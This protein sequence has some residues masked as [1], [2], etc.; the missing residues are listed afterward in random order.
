LETEINEILQQFE[1]AHVLQKTNGIGLDTKFSWYDV[2][3][4]NPLFHR[5]F[6]GL[7]KGCGMQLLPGDD[8]G[9][10]NVRN[11]SFRASAG[12]VEILLEGDDSR[13]RIILHAKNEADAMALEEEII[14]SLESLGMSLGEPTEDFASSL[15]RSYF[16]V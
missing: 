5:L 3:P 8:D 4:E 6:Y 9:L 16:V 1:L 10:R 15:N 11:A 14:R 13:P 2:V 7:E 12:V